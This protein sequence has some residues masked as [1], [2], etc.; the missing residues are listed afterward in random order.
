MEPMISEAVVDIMLHYD[1][2]IG[3]GIA[4]PYAANLAREWYYG[5]DQPF[6]WEDVIQ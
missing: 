4:G 5:V 6:D 1:F 3:S 2:I